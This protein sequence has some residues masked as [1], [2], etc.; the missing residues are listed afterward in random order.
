MSFILNID[1]LSSAA[2]R[3]RVDYLR[4][5]YNSHEA[6]IPSVFSIIDIVNYLYQ[7]NLILNQDSFDCF[8]SK[9]HAASVIYPFLIDKGLICFDDVLFAHEGSKYGI[10]ANVDIPCIPM[11]SGSLGHG[12]GVVSGYLHASKS[13]KP[14]FLF[15]GDGECFEGSIHEA[16]IFSALKSYPNLYIIIDANNRT[17]LGDLDKTFPGYDPSSVFR[18]LSYDVISF[19]GHDYFD[20]HNAFTRSFE[21]TSRKPKVLLAHTIKGKGIGFMESSHLWHNKMPSKD[22]L[23]LAISQLSLSC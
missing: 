13:T 18:S 19:D 20:I 9:G 1:S 16:A 4:L 5:V 8:V 22:Q 12:L 23:D 10:Y 14:T 7:R 3:F 21:S 17:I 2:A 15:L 6:L 11:P